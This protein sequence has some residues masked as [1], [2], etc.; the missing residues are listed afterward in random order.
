MTFARF[1]AALVDA[2]RGVDRAYQVFDRARSTIVARFASDRLLQA[3]NDRVYARTPVYQPGSPQFRSTFFNWE[4]AAIAAWF[5]R[6]PA[7]VLVGGAGGGR[8]PLALAKMGY[9]VT[10]FEPSEPLVEAIPDAGG[11]IAAHVGRYEDLPVVRSMVRREHVDLGAAPPFDAAIFGWSSYS[12][13]RRAD[14]RVAAV[15]SLAAL[16][17]GPIL[18]SMFLAPLQARP[19]GRIATLAA[20]LHLRSPHDRF[21]PAIGFYHLSTRDELYAECERAGV[22][23]VQFSDD[24]SDGAWP[25]CVVTRGA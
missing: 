22:A 18:I 9:R 3:Y 21:G 25:Y 24:G 19:A 20:R 16:V 10:A 4:A 14:D 23:V 13:I 6:P 2:S 11:A 17:E 12:H 1:G 15:R 8:E 5:P 7:R